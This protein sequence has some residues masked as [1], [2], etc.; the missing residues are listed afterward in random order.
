MEQ[1]FPLHPIVVPLSK[2][3][4]RLQALPI[5]VHNTEKTGMGMGLAI[6]KWA[7]RPTLAPSTGMLQGQ[8]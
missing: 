1:N 8:I 2:Q 6:N 5:A 3:L 4:A 7:D